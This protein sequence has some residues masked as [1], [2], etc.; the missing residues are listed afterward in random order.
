MIFK[1]IPLEKS[2]FAQHQDYADGE[3]V[4]IAAYAPNIVTDESEAYTGGYA[5]G[6]DVQIVKGIE[7]LRG[8]FYTRIESVIE[9]DFLP[10]KTN[11]SSSR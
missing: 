4:D 2:L 5:E 1:E 10:A 3:N 11:K 7:N 6:G 9:L 8:K